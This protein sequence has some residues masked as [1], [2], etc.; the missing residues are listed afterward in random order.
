[1]EMIISRCEMER[2]PRAMILLVRCRVPMTLAGDQGVDVKS[3]LEKY[4]P[5]VRMKAM[6]QAHPS[7]LY[8]PNLKL[9]FSY[10]HHPAGL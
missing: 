9:N 8:F 1:M 7:S 2:G 6:R 4:R 5:L 10:T 3:S